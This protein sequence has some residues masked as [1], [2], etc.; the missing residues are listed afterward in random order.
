M[1]L[2]EIGREVVDNIHLAQDRDQ[3]RVN[4]VI[5]RVP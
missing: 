5:D 3:W 2:T 4:T 1:D